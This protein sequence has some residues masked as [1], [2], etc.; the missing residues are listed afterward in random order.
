V[1]EI[2]AFKVFETYA[3]LLITKRYP[4]PG[5]HLYTIDLLTNEVKLITDI[6]RYKTNFGACVIN[7]F[8]YIIGGT[9]EF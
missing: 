9:T 5:N 1:K 4:V 3:H 2:R 7:D 8:V 6:L